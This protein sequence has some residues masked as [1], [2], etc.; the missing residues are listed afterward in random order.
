MKTYDGVPCA[1]GRIEAHDEEELFGPVSSLFVVELERDLLVA[2]VA[3]FD[4]ALL[5]V[6][7]SRHDLCKY[8]G[9]SK[10]RKGEIAVEE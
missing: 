10:R 5:V 2:G 6:D 7:R 9:V 1:S 3:D 4:V 8:E